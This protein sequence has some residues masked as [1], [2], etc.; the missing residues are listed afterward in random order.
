MWQ[1]GMAELAA[2]L[3]LMCEPDRVGWLCAT[4][5]A[6]SRWQVKYTRMIAIAILQAKRCSLDL[7]HMDTHYRNV[8]HMPAGGAGML[9]PDVRVFSSPTRQMHRCIDTSHPD[10]GATRRPRWGHMGTRCGVVQVIQLP[11]WFGMFS[12]VRRDESLSFKPRQALCNIK[13]ATT[14]VCACDGA[15]QENIDI[16][17]V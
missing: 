7:R 16:C 2:R 8:S 4:G 12:F 5:T 14:F 17:H 3:L 13:T 10:L 15:K 1:V 11:F 9:Q 6:P